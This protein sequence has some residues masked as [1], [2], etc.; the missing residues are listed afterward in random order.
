[1]LDADEFRETRFDHPALCFR[2]F[3]PWRG[4]FRGHLLLA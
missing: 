3:F 4:T 2:C 1:V